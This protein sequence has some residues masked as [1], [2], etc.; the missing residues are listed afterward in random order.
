[1]AIRKSNQFDLEDAVHEA[2]NTFGVDCYDLMCEV[3]PEVAKDAVKKLRKDSPKRPRGGR[4]AKGWKATIEQKRLTVGATIHNKD[5]YQL[6]HLLE[7]GHAKRG[8]GRVPAKPHIAPVNDWAVD[9]VY[10]RIVTAL[11]R[12]TR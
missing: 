1:M 11:E 2:L 12:G 6:A 7:K 10:E 3:I 9:E 5:R 4:Y 8:G